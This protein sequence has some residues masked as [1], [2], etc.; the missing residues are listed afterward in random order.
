MFRKYNSILGS[1]R[2][3]EI[4]WWLEKYPELSKE[5]YILTEKIHGANISWVFEPD[6]SFKIAKRNG[7]IEEDAFYNHKIMYEEYAD[8]IIILKDFVSLLG[9]SMNIYGEWFGKG[10]QK[11]VNYGDKKRLLFFDIMVNNTIYTPFE[12]ES[13]FQELDLEDMIVPTFGK[14]NSLQEALDFETED[15]VSFVYPEGKDIIEGVVIKPY[16]NSFLNGDGSPFYIKKKNESFEEKCSKKKVLK[17][18]WP[19]S[20]ENMK[21]I[22][23]SYLTENRLNNVISKEGEIKSNKDIGKYIRLLMADAQEEFTKDCNSDILQLDKK[24][25][26]YVYNHSKEVVKMIRERM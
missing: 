4:Q 6:G 22:F 8:I 26:K 25:L 12:M 20:V 11:G 17:T 16:Y 14:V 19:E 9:C 2:D 23:G 1:W 15:K 7:F 21:A 13:M 24:E 5:T 18:V 3:K 10:I